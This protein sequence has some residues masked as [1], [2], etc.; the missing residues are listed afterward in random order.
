VTTPA[1][2]HGRVP[3]RISPSVWSDEVERL[4]RG[5]AGRIAAE[6]ERPRLET[7]G[8]TIDDVLRRVD[9]GPDGTRL[10][11]QF[12][13]Y[14][15]IAD[16]PASRRPFGFVLSPRTDEQG[17][18]FVVLAFG[19]RHPRRGTRSVYERAHKRLHGRYPDQ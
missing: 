15:P 11:S 18:Y 14:V 17:L 4:D 2:G 16:A 3:V 7:L 19:E 1:P 6:R 13:L 10:A 12:K 8:V 5:S 9:P